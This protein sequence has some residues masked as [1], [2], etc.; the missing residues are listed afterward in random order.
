[1]KEKGQSKHTNTSRAGKHKPVRVLVL[2]DRSVG[3]YLLRG[4]ERR[5]CHCSLA[6]SAEGAAELMRRSNFDLV[7]STI[8]FEQNDPLISQLSGSQCT[9]LYCHP[10]EGTWLPIMSR[11]KRCIDAPAL[12]PI[13]VIELVDSMAAG[14]S[15]AATA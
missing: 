2:G 13:G 7:V 4:L 6:T 1:M 8:L 9:V 14:L 5:G 12:S 10:V 3:S 15:D 11:G